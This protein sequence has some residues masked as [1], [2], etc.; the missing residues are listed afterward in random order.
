MSG[1]KASNFLRSFSV[2]MLAASTAAP[3]EAFADR[4]QKCVA[5]CRQMGYQWSFCD[6]KCSYDDS[7][8]QNS[9]IDLAE[10]F[11]NSGLAGGARQG[12]QEGQRQALIQQ[13]IENQRLQ[14]EILRR[15]LEGQ[16]TPPPASQPPTTQRY[17]RDA[18]PKEYPEQSSATR[19]RQNDTDAILRLRKAAELG[20]A[21]A[22]TSLGL[23]YAKGEGVPKDS[24][25]AVEWFRKA[26]AQGNAVATNNL[27]WMY[28]NGEGVS[29]SHWQAFD[30]YR[31]AAERGSVL[32]NVNLGNAYE[33]GQGVPKN[34]NEALAWYRKAA[35]LGHE[36][37]K[38]R[39]SGIEKTLNQQSQTPETNV[40]IEMTARSRAGNEGCEVASIN[41]V[42]PPTGFNFAY[43]ISCSDS[44]I[45][46]YK[47]NRSDCSLVS[48]VPPMGFQTKSKSKWL[49]P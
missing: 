24:V 37:A 33:M 14:N 23:G 16:R 34:Y 21:M 45:R 12:Y 13:Q 43:E 15:Q 41:N 2:L 7:Q 31:V 36:G 49:N 29:Q 48:V 40:A 17:D 47:C 11:R 44:S 10:I 35:N 22:Q 9:D 4:D 38:Q 20:D 46:K 32:A 26:A 25:A 18:P 6:S 30:L 8:S 27:G 28:A 42:Q 19:S 3:L 39:I 1:I 5:D